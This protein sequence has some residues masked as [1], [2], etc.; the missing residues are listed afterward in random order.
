MKKVTDIAERPGRSRPREI[1][2]AERD[3]IALG[4]ATAGIIMFVG[5][6]GTVVP[7]VIRSLAGYGM[8]PDKVLVNAL[9]LN[10]ALI[11]F[12][13]R[14]YRQL[15]QEVRERRRAEEQARYLAETDPLTGLLN[16][17]GFADSVDE[18]IAS[19]H[20]AREAVA[21]MMIDLDN[22]KQVNDFHG[23]RMGDIL[24]TRSAERISHALPD[25]CLLA[26]I[27]GDEFACAMKFDLSHEDAVEQQAKKI[28]EAIS[29]PLTAREVMME[30][31]A[32]IGISR[33]DVQ[34][35]DRKG[36]TPAADLFELADIAMYH[37]KRQ[38]RNCYFW[39]D[40]HMADEM[41]FRSELE[42][43]IRQ[44]ILA[45]E[46]VPYYEK[47]IDLQTGKLTGFE[48]L[49]RWNS[50]RFG[51]VGPDIFIP[52]AE[53]I[54]AIAALSETLIAQ[55]FEDAKT[56]EG[57]LTLAVNISPL[58]L[59]DPWF[60]QKLLKLLVAANF[61]P[62]R[63][64][65]EITESCLHEDIGLVR[66]LIGSL[67]NQGIRVSIDDFGTGYSSLSQLGNFPFDRIKIDR[68]FVIN[69]ARSEDSAAIVHAIAMLGKDL[70]LPITVE[71]IE[72]QEVLDCLRK[73]GE[74][75]GQGYL[76]GQPSTAD[77]TRD[78]LN[79]LRPV[80]DEVATAEG[81]GSQSKV[82]P[83]QRLAGNG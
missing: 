6:G 68:S 11:I 22:F 44:G 53:E 18:L 35:P 83:S 14:R 23:H 36:G 72:T 45:G 58:Q 39:F 59:R 81:N 77:D 46:F 19:I 62:E 4:I 29:Q 78:W 9:L 3:I 63:L 65:I 38:G 50:A 33:S 20:P 28:V 12:G 13:W 43:A 49:A 69:L 80:L 31:T 32:S 8:G 55:A 57:D 76:Y 17:R 34:L 70:K 10:I 7:Q 48:M 54:G 67:K 2:H 64:E 47:Q 71:G 66:T 5:T 75:K 56:W 30:V 60:A 51:T 73:Y 42:T 21:L 16:K 61:P 52:I 1:G 15:S 40:S 74:L 26:R 79:S 25:Q 82:A 27:G 37:A 24:L 41:L